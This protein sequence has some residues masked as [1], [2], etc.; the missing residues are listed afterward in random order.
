MGAIPALLRPPHGV[1]ECMSHWIKS[2]IEQFSYPGIVFLMLL[3]NV[4]PPIPSEL[5]IPLSGFVS[6]QGRLSIVG[7]I[8]AGT[9]GSV[10]GAVVLYYV[11]R[12]IGAERLRRW[13]ETRG[14]WVGLSTADLDKSDTWF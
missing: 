2:V 1:G 12:G 4:F 9:L 5:I 7:V 13:T 10:A 11:G 8:V 14:H 6:T 3:E